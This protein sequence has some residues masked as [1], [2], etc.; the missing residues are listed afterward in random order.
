MF[1]FTAYY[2]S[3]IRP[4][5]SG[6]KLRKEKTCLNC[7]HEVSHRYCSY[8]GQKNTEP[9]ENLW[10][11]LFHFLSDLVHF[12]GSFFKTL[13]TLFR[14]P[15]M[16]AEDYMKGKRRSY[17][18]PARMYIFT[19]ALFFLT[20]FSFPAAEILFRTIL[21][22]HEEKV[23][24]PQTSQA[25]HAYDIHRQ[26]ITPQ[27][28][29]EL[30]RMI[31]ERLYAPDSGE[32][33]AYTV[34]AYDSFQQTLLPKERDGMLDRFIA[35]KSIEGRAFAESSPMLFITK[36][37]ETFTHSFSQICIVSLPIFSFFLYLLYFPKRRKYYFVSHA[38]LAIHIY[39]TT[40][41]LMI[42]FIYLYRLIY[43]YLQE[44]SINLAFLFL[45]GFCYYLYRSM[46]YF[47]KEHWLLTAVKFFVLVTISGLSMGLLFFVYFIY[48]LITGLSAG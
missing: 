8:C 23:K 42:L 6:S 24:P 14:K 25:E 38:V 19:S 13:F 11:M 43:P 4:K 21:I 7:G 17:L 30:A 9:R 28:K 22:L 16:A 34:A 37:A 35:R 33:D 46:L 18:D 12:E 48:S 40:F 10:Q 45:P 36:C 31:V 1:I 32:I 27:K 20:A 41:I 2:L 39:C 44:K 47:Y 5:V 26:K 3:V 15:G 29:E